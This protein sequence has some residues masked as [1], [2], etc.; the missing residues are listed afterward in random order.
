MGNLNGD[1]GKRG[2]VMGEYEK[3]YTIH[4]MH[5]CSITLICSMYMYM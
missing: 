2:I 4:E 3:V 5:T 1:K